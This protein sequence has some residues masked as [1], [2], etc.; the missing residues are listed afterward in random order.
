MTPYHYDGDLLISV[1]DLN[2]K[3]YPKLSYEMCSRCLSVLKIQQFILNREQIR[4]M[5]TNP[6]VPYVKVNEV[7]RHIPQLTYMAQDQHQAK[8]ART[9]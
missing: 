8:R 9:S 6:K 3:L 1:V 5:E 4:V 7:S 2:Q